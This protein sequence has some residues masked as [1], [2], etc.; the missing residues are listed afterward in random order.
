MLDE[1][2]IE[3]SGSPERAQV[4]VVKQRDKKRLVID[5]S[6]TINCFT[7]LDSYMLSRME[8]IVSQVAQDMFYSSIRPSLSVPPSSHQKD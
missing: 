2:I 7:R 3:P 5:Y 1:D 6:A 4:R 8:S